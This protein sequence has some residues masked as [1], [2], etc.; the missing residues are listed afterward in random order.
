M[1]E[2]RDT[3]RDQYGLQFLG[4]AIG[5]VALGPI[6]AVGLWYVGKQADKWVN[7]NRDRFDPIK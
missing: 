3:S 7:N 6:G 1:T 4:A 2:Q 5:I